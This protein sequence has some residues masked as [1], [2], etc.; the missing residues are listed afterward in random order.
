MGSLKD[1][2]LSSHR[3]IG[4]P[5]GWCCNVFVRRLIAQSVRGSTARARRGLLGSPPTQPT[6]WPGRIQV[7]CSL[8]PQSACS[9]VP[10]AIR[11]IFQ[12]RLLP[13]TAVCSGGEIQRS[14]P[15]ARRAPTDG[16][17]IQIATK[18]NKSHK[19]TITKLKNSVPWCLR[20]M[21]FFQ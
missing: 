19:G 14:S 10:G 20:V 15:R 18:I 3:G 8:L 21:L 1:L 9:H 17:V 13:T 6:V 11:R 2:F 7:R 4:A 16:L 12:H 5:L